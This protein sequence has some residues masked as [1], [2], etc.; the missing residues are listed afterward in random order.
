MFAYTV[1]NVRQARRLRKP[2]VATHR[3]AG[4][5]ADALPP[6]HAFARYSAP[7]TASFGTPTP[8]IKSRPN[9]SQLSR[10]LPPMHAVASY[11]LDRI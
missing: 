4:A 5:H 2:A 8:P 10:R 3:V 7:A 9:C 11:K 6:L 1:F